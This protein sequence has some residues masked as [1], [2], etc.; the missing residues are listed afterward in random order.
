MTTCELPELNRRTDELQDS[1]KEDH[2]NYI[3]EEL[4]ANMYNIILNYKDDLNNPAI[5][6]EANKLLW[7]FSGKLA[8]IDLKNENEKI[9]NNQHVER[10]VKEFNINFEKHIIKEHQDWWVFPWILG[11]T[12]KFMNRNFKWL[13]IWS[14]VWRVFIE[15]SQSAWVLMAQKLSKMVSSLSSRTFMLQSLW[16]DKN[17][18]MPDPGKINKHD[19]EEDWKY[20]DNLLKTNAVFDFL[21]KP[22]DMLM[23]IQ[24]KTMSPVMWR[25][26][27]QMYRS[28]FDEKYMELAIRESK[29]WADKN[30]PIDKTN[31]FLFKDNI[32]T[33]NQIRKRE[34]IEEAKRLAR[35]D[36]S[37]L[38][39]NYSN[40]PLIIHKMEQFLPF[41]NFLYSGVRL[42]SKF[43]KSFLFAATALNNLQYAYGDEVWYMDDEWERVDA[44]ISL[45]LPIL[46]WIG[47][48]SVQMNMQRMLQYSPT[49]TSISPL[50]IFSFVTNREDF[51][52]K[53]FY[54]KWDMKSL[55]NVAL[56]MMW[57]TIQQ[58]Y[59]WI[60]DLDKPM[61]P[62]KKE[63]AT[64]K[65]TQALCYMATWMVIKDKTQQQAWK[66][67]IEKDYN[68]LLWLTQMQLNQF[69]KHP[70]NVK[71]WLTVDS[72]KAAKFA[73]E[74]WLLRTDYEKDP[75]SALLDAMSGVWLHESVVTSKELNEDQKQISN[76]V[77]FTLW[78]V[79]E[80]WNS[81]PD[82][83][84]KCVDFSR[85]A[86][87]KEFKNFNET[88][89][90][91]FKHFADNADWYN[92]DKDARDKMFSE[93][94][95]K[96]KEW[97]AKSLA[98][99]YRFK[100]D[101]WM[102]LE[103]KTSAIISGKLT[104][105]EYTDG[106]KEDWL[107]PWPLMTEW[108]YNSLDF[109]WDAVANYMWQANKVSALEKT[110][111]TFARLAWFS[112]DSKQEDKYW[113]IANAIY[114]KEKVAY[115]QF[116]T[117]AT[118]EFDLFFMSK[119]W[120]KFNEYSKKQDEYLAN[121]AHKKAARE[122]HKLNTM[123]KMWEKEKTFYNWIL[124][125]NIDA[126][127][128]AKIADM[129]SDLGNPYYKQQVINQE[130]FNN[131]INTINHGN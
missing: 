69:F 30:N 79:K 22:A 71:N 54:T 2:K 17:Y 45:R 46:A 36:A 6:N 114:D 29:S 27:N 76:L 58:L 123:F 99:K 16:F 106:S 78:S 48:W 90:N 129:F 101:E 104:I 56:G 19:Y 121:K 59:E 118:P 41:S 108:Y 31:E 82:F 60:R 91:T 67:Y 98:L 53:E 34:I 128:K 20:Q 49:S 126:K 25:L 115:K 40:N 119:E 89:Y 75:Q 86:H 3:K 109:K 130:K 93:D 32:T 77:E 63:N 35:D 84:K 21:S 83:I 131:I 102:T 37:K 57:P 74:L 113:K 52:W 110:R 47:L 44:W 1:L 103:E 100:W 97:T 42:L 127:S 105:P 122:W 39:F 61:D 125:T 18:S 92:E 9:Y 94:T 7:D 96:Q 28:L 38:F 112:T 23:S 4:T 62:V 26:E 124:W 43:P 73:T 55:Q 81:D 24:S 116:A 88:M 64:A 65:I 66:W 120:I 80:W 68:S 11:S 51:R 14:S 107:P 33:E 95:S 8:E 10:S 87:F 117:T 85:S 5:K 15:S 12:L 50:P 111:S 72:I 13:A 70:T